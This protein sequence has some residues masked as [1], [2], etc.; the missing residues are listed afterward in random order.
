MQPHVKIY[1]AINMKFRCYMNLFPVGAELPQAWSLSP[2]LTF[3]DRISRLVNDVLPL[4][5]VSSDLNV[6]LEW[7]IVDIV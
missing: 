1:T 3:M 6:T 2:V 7:F 5:Y 4:G